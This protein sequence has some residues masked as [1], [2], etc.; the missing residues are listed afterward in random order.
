MHTKL[1]FGTVAGTIPSGVRSVGPQIHKNT[2]IINPRPQGHFEE[3]TKAEN[4]PNDIKRATSARQSGA[5]WTKRTDPLGIQSKRTQLTTD[6]YNELKQGISNQ[7]P[8]SAHRHPIGV[9]VVEHIQIQPANSIITH[10][11]SPHLEQ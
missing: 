3:R 10:I 11:T 5:T 8:R 7:G 6:R 4:S 2:T 1:E 9:Q